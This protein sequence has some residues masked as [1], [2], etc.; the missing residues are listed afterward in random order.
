[1]RRA[2]LI[3]LALVVAVSINVVRLETDTDPAQAGAGRLLELPS[4]TLR[5]LEAGRFNRQTVVLLHG[6]GGSLKWWR[7]VVPELSRYHRVISFDLLGHGGSDKPREGYSIEEQGRLIAEALR[8]LR[9]D[10]VTLVGHSL[11]GLVA[12]AVA[13][14]DPFA[15]R[16]LVLIST[17]TQQSHNRPPAIAKLMFTPVIGHTIYTL[18]PSSML[19]E[20][21]TIAFSDTVVPP[22]D[23][24]ADIPVMTYNS[25]TATSRAAEQFMET[26]P[27]LV[28]RLREL[29]LPVLAIWGDDDRLWDRA[30]ADDYKVL[31][32]ATVKMIAGAGHCPHVESPTEVTRLLREFVEAD[33]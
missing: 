29:E 10:N 14:T 6:W 27:G 22:P 17:P 19:S 25:M 2:A 9:A 28:A 26:E 13:E 11:G 18:T 7:T 15:F 1:M 12:T 31:P 3:L 32:A 33:W 4:A 23:L 24:L 21:A 5:V 20:S 8:E 30:S 16:G